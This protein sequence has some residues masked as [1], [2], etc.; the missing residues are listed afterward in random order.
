MQE[1]LSDFGDFGFGFGE[2]S[3]RVLQLQQGDGQLSALGGVLA[4]RVES[5]HEF[6]QGQALYAQENLALNIH[7]LQD[8]TS[9]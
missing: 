1:Q 5:R 8:D 6:G 9:L 2:A 4:K 3:A 7:M